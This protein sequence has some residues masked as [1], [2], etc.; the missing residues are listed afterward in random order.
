MKKLKLKLSHVQII[1]LGFLIL[2][3]VGTVLLCLPFST[4][5]GER[6]GLGISFFTAVSA[7]TVTGFTLQ[8]TVTFWSDF[9]H[10]V[11]LLLFQVIM[12]GRPC[13]SS[14]ISSSIMS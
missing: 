14:C 13:S 1:A 2:I 12:Q 5:S 4:A 10:V 7:A 8:D 11:I 3:A 9:G 6:A